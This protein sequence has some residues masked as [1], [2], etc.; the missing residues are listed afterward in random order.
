MDQESDS[1]GTSPGMG[2]VEGAPVIVR[3]YYPACLVRSA[4]EVVK[5][6]GGDL[7]APILK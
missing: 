5:H 2:G 1:I 6:L 3:V 7:S 4:S